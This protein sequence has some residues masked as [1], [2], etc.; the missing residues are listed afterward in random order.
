M[1]N[2][3]EERAE[4]LEALGSAWDAKPE[5][6]FG[7]LLLDIL[8][9]EER[10]DELRRLDDSWLSAALDSYLSVFGPGS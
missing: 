10:I 9:P 8:Q 3:E 7:K 5:L 4:I 1:S 2:R 6:P